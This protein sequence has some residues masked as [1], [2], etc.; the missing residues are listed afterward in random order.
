[1]TESHII[2]HNSTTTTTV[3]LYCT[4]LSVYSKVRTVVQNLQRKKYVKLFESDQVKSYEVVLL[5]FLTITI[6]GFYMYI[7]D[8]YIGMIIRGRSGKIKVTLSISYYIYIILLLYNTHDGWGKERWMNRHALQ[9]MHG[10]MKV[11]VYIIY[12]VI[13]IRY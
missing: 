8:Q 4:V 7:R 2:Q 9:E 13:I 12:N 3:L 11:L 10:K 1:M 5:G 6:L